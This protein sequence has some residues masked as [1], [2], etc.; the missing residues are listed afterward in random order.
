[1]DLRNS[2]ARKSLRR[3]S[4]PTLAATPLA[5]SSPSRP[6]SKA[7]IIAPNVIVDGKSGVSGAG[8]GLALGTHYSEVNESVRAYSMDGHRHLP[9]I[10]QELRMN[11]GSEPR[12][13][14]L[15][16]L[17]P[18]TRGILSSCYADII[19]GS[20]PNGDEAAAALTEIYRDFYQG[21]TFA[22]VVDQPPH[23]KHTL[24][25][26]DCLVYPTI[27]RRTD[28]LTVVSAIDNLVKG[29]AGQAVQN[30]N[31]MFGLPE[32]MGLETLA[33]YP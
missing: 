26:N 27:D 12:V 11:G 10:T 20:L 28:R 33:L 1:M 18:M 7:G 4:W 16:H 22:K 3:V 5:Q 9:E 17:I 14:F 21:E 6:L 25:N 30:M 13:T 29:A 19:P 2:I 31:L 15:P 32:S 24:G 8:R 23:T